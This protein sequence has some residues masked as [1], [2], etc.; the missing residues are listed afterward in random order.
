[1]ATRTRTS[2]TPS[3]FLFVDSTLHKS[4]SNEAVK[5][6]A[7]RRWHRKREQPRKRSPLAPPKGGELQ[8][9]TQ[10]TAVD[11]PVLE[12]LP[13]PRESVTSQAALCSEPSP[14]TSRSPLPC[15][16]GRDATENDDHT[17]SASPCSTLGAGRCDPFG[18]YP[19]RQSRFVDLVVDWCTSR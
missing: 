9:W 5:V 3:D 11:S 13:L 8:L 12:S 1:M 10:Y 18:Q 14:C 19:Y 7:M 2:D 4:V 6:N 16:S 17:S 15:G